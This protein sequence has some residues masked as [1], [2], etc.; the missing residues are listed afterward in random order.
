MGGIV[1]GGSVVGSG[2]GLIDINII[3]GIVAEYFITS[4]LH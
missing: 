2:V 1:V 3:L 4:Q